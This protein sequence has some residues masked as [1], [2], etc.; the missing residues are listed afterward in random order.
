[1]IGFVMNRLGKTEQNMLYD[2]SLRFVSQ[3]YDEIVMFFNSQLKTAQRQY[4]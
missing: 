2:T 1:M 4:I 3:D